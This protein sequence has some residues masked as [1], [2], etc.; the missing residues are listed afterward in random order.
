MV[1]SFELLITREDGKF[2]PDPQPLRYA[3]EKLGVE[4][5]QAWMVGDGSYDVQASNAAG[6]RSVWISHGREKEFPNE[7]WRTV[8]DLVELLRL[9]RN[10]EH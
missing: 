3:C 9:L 10:C 6:I 5:S 1:W 8:R 4:P 2:K 7:P